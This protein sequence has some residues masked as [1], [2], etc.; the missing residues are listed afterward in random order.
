MNNTFD[1]NRFL[2]LLKREFL[3]GN[4]KFLLIAAA[5]FGVMI[6]NALFQIYTGDGYTD[7]SFIT[8]P[9]VLII[10]GLIFTSV[11]FYE[12]NTQTGT[13]HYLNLPAST[14]EKFLSKWFITFIIF[15]IAAILFFGLYAFIADSIYNY[16]TG[17]SVSTF[18]LTNWWSLFFIR[19]YLVTQS[20]F[21]VGAIAFQ[22][23]TLFKTALVG[24]LSTMVFA[25]ACA[26]MI[27]IIFAEYFETLFLPREDI[28]MILSENAINFLEFKLLNWVEYAAY[29]LLPP[30]MWVVGFFK[31]K[32]KEA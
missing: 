1:F 2:L 10:G 26:I 27:R 6:C 15:P 5:V 29:F 8:F 23:F 18:D 13:H 17:K 11:I 31:L 20:L 12:F 25:L 19:I 16:S 30:T 3:S 24:W 22:K 32:E 9:L 14:L 21:L 7:S 28:T 4:K